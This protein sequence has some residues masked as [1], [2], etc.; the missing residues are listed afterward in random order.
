MFAFAYIGLFHCSSLSSW[1]CLRVRINLHGLILVFAFDYMDLFGSSPL[2]L[3][4]C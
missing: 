1:T 4:T 3:C 2:S